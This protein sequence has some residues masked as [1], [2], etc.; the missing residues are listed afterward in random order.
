MPKIFLLLFIFVINLGF[1]QTNKDTYEIYSITLNGLVKNWFDPP[2]NGLIVVEQYK[3]KYKP[4]FIDIQDLTISEIPK[5]TLAWYVRDSL[6]QQRFLNDNNIKKVLAGLFY[7]FNNHPK[8]QVDLLNIPN[9][10]LNIIPSEKYYSY[11][12]RGSKWRKNGW[13]RLSKKYDSK[14]AIQFSKINYSRNYASLYYE[15]LCGGLCAA[16]AVVLM[17]KIGDEWRIVNEFNLWES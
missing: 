13:K 10:K 7:N 12:N 3:A 6:V 17:E 16:G 15:Y 5:T 1:A 9:V 4:D 8:I 14:F 2:V 11:L